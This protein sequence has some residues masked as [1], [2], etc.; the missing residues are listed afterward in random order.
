MDTQQ[1]HNNAHEPPEEP[2]PPRGAAPTLNRPFR[3]I[4]LMLMAYV[5]SVVLYYTISESF[6]EVICQSPI[7]PG[8]FPVCKP[9]HQRAPV[10]NPDFI[11]LS[12]LQSRLEYV[13][14]DS[15]ISLV[16]ADSVKG[17][18]RE[19]RDLIKEVKFSPF[20]RKD[21]MRQELEDIV[22]GAKVAGE[23]LQELSSRVRG[24]TDEIISL[25]DRIVVVLQIQGGPFSRFVN[26]L[27]P[28]GQETSDA[29]RRRTEGA[30]WLQ[31]FEL[32]E[33]NLG[34]LI[35]RTNANV[36]L[37]RRLE[38][39]LNTIQDM[40]V[41][42]EKTL[43][44]EEQE[45]KRQWFP[46]W[47]PDEVKKSESR[48]AGFELLLKVRDQRQHALDQVTGMLSVLTH[49]SYELRNLRKSA[50]EPNIAAGLSDIPTEAYIESIRSGTE[51]L[52]HGQTRAREIEVAYRKKKLCSS[53]SI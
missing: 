48:S 21:S 11:T 5:V 34:K 7:L 6:P 13:L 28:F 46:E 37:L 24:A 26:L 8:Y 36:G 22:E 38:V 53:H 33:T 10:V 52:L 42:E 17:S 39:R 40:T 47:F 20:T 49:M 41:T 15:A 51:R 32:L 4:T 25:N 12:R 35:H 19:L 29:R 45:F 3:V 30:L 9:D 1:E 23:S 18:T 44:D 50:G 31:A 27:L 2:L 16:G 14:E 43:L